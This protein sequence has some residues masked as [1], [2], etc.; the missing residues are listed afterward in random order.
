MDKP[1]QQTGFSGEMYISIFRTDKGDYE[2]CNER[3]DDELKQD[4][5]GKRGI[6]YSLVGYYAR[7][8]SDFFGVVLKYIDEVNKGSDVEP[9][10]VKAGLLL[11]PTLLQY[12]ASDN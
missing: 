8:N 12:C 6:G 9:R 10:E 7:V 4:I 5:D 3:S 11:L 2:V 1:R